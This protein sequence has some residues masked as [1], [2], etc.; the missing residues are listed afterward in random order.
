VAVSV[1]VL[2]DDLEV[3]GEDYQ[4]HSHRSSPALTLGHQGGTET[5]S[6]LRVGK[7]PCSVILKEG[8]ALLGSQGRG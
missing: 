1:K 6:S 8:S 3:T 5:S 7:E 4:Y 2:T